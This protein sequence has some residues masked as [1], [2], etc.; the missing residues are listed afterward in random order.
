MEAT[1]K[2]SSGRA[3]LDLPK[4][5][6]EGDNRMTRFWTSRPASGAIAPAG[7]V[8]QR[9]FPVLTAKRSSLVMVS[10]FLGSLAL[11][12]ET[13]A[14]WSAPATWTPP[15]ARGVT[16]LSETPP[17]PFIPITPCRVADTRGNGF[18]GAYGPPS[19]GAGT[20][21]SF[22]IA[23]QCGIPAAAAAVSFN[24]TA[25][26]VSAAG[27][28]R[29]FPAGGAVPTV[30]TLN[31]NASTP[32]IAN[33]AVVPLGTGGAIRVQA[34]ATTIDLI[35]DVNGYYSPMLGNPANFFT[36]ENN[37]TNYTMFLHNAN[38]SCAG[39]CGLFTVADH[40]SA[41]WGES[42][43]A[44]DGVYGVSDDASG[45][46]V[47]GVVTPNLSDS[48]AVWGEH[49]STGTAGIGV[50]GSHAGTGIGVQ[51]ASLGTTGIGAIGVLGQAT[52]SSDDTAGVEGNA[53]AASGRTYGVLGITSGGDNSAGVRGVGASGAMTGDTG[54][55]FL[56]S[57]V[58]GVE[59]DNIGVLGL[60]EN[61]A[62]DFVLFNPAGT[63]VAQAFLGYNPGTAYGVYA[64]I[65]TIAC[66]GCTKLFV[67][68]H[69]SDASKVI[70]YVSL[71]GN[72]AGTYF[73][74]T[75]RTFRGNA[76]I[77]VPEDFRIVTDEE[78][79]TVQLTPVGAEASMY[80]VSEDLNQIVVHSSSDVTFH[81]LVQ[82]IRPD[83]KNFKAIV[84]GSEYVPEGPDARMPAAWPEKV[85][86]ALVSNGTYNADGSINRATASRLGWDRVWEQRAR[87]AARDTVAVPVRP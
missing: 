58:R 26:N 87:A 81:Y 30:S 8:D 62:G 2:R 78:G 14:N 45:A 72:E 49:K 66:N 27:D 13:I 25:L 10:F 33:A 40:G 22:T 7:F 60:S 23:G 55:L 11:C 82:G 85:K 73:R 64:N 50:Y 67:E 56:S 16:T 68:P 65:G 20:Q 46:G 80:V 12:G 59:K 31:Y 74:G 83:Y 71:E 19:I 48:R 75:T 57:G 86:R 34:D 70:H 47:H 42:G 1:L 84:D 53:F 9:R 28:L 39:Q 32:N 38:S 3:S 54:T 77:P 17:V 52:S 18:T 76:V 69:P 21:R 79:L 43:T 61:L 35:I 36:L 15:R 4:A 37:S 63:K 44:G 51:G 29:V 24:F 5:R 6:S 41:V